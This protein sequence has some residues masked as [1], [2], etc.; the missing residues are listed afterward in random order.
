[1]RN[2]YNESVSLA[3]ACLKLRK[4]MKNSYAVER[5]EKKQKRIDDEWKNFSMKRKRM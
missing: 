3:E 4:C 1:M 5:Y 2:L